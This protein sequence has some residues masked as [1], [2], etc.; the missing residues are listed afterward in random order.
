M[1]FFVQHWSKDTDF[2]IP[3]AWKGKCAFGHFSLARDLPTCLL[4]GNGN[5]GMCSDDRADCVLVKSGIAMGG[6]E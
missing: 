5:M 6:F 3:L 2:R 1:L 4:D